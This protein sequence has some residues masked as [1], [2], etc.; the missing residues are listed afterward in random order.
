MSPDPR[1]AAY[2]AVRVAH[3]RHDEVLKEVEASLE[4][5]DRVTVLVGPTGVGKSNLLARLEASARNRFAKAPQVGGIPYMHVDAMPPQHA[6]FRWPGF[7]HS[8]LVQADEVLPDRKRLPQPRAKTSEALQRSAFT[9]L[10]QRRPLIFCIDEAQHMS[11]ASKPQTQRRTFALVKQLASECPVP[12]LMAGTYQL[13][14][15]IQLDGQTARRFHHIPFRPY[16]YESDDLRS[17]LAAAKYLLEKCPV[18][19]HVDLQ[20]DRDLLFRGSVGSVGILK[21]WLDRAL[22][23]CLR[24]STTLTREVLVAS[25][26]ANGKLQTIA[27]EYARGEQRLRQL[28]GDEDELSALLG[29]AVLPK[30]RAASITARPGQ[31][32]IARDRVGT[33]DEAA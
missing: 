16:R 9:V 5:N 26:E 19:H 2:R 25:R 11:F 8:V 33:S 3:S 29:M 31:R 1:L 23:R 17:F 22:A 15:F 21:T 28:D 32:A 12:I 18:R 20:R 7:F 24:E 10:Q 30:A 27:Q 6:D 14:D 13:L 4:L